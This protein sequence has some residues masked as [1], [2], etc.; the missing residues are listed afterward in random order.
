METSM[1]YYILLFAIFLFLKNYL[2]KTNRQLPPSPGLSLPI[3]GHLY[4]FKKPIHK[5][6]AKLSDKYGPIVYIKFGSRPVILVS[7]PSAVEECFTKHDVAFA[8]RPKLLAG[9]Y[10]GY[11]YT[12]VTWA[13]YG[14]HWRNLRR[15]SSI[16]LLSSNRLQILQGIRA[17]EVSSLI[18]RLFRGSNGGEFQIL[19]MKSTFFQLTLNVM[20]RIVAGKRY[21][22]ED[23]ADLEEAKRFQQIVAETFQLT[24]VTN[25]G[26]FVPV[27][28]YVGVSKLEKK[29][30]ILQKKRDKFLQDL[31]VQHRQMQ[32]DSASEQRSKTMVDV[33]LS[34]QG[35]EPEYYTDE[36]IRGMMHVML[37]AGTDTTSGTMEWAL[38]LLLNNPEA[39]AKA[40]SEIDE[41]IGQSRLVEESDLAKLPYLSCIINET[42]RMYPAAPLLPPHEASE[43][44]TVGGFHVPRGT[45]LLV[46]AWAIQ[47]DPELWAKPELFKPER[48]Q[49]LQGERDGFKWLPFGTG[50]RGCPGEGLA[51]RIVGLA[52]GS[53]IQCFEWERS[54]EEMVDMT[55]RAGLAMPKAH[56]LLAKCRPRPTMLAFLSQLQVSKNIF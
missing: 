36:I 46:N 39:L 51:T 12:T 17:D 11:N 2:Q 38:S 18:F 28:N 26:D 49:N 5:T 4:L 48:F 54:G 44:C 30:L 23:I 42:L 8:N 35:T 41:Q 3:I 24:G 32:S 6:L 9:K 21:Y 50:R 43:D 14:S 10:L 16:E 20:M 53:L 25:I 13:S 7:S 31:I 15:I 22:G 40:Q 45:M 27:L 52:L 55:E 1:Y 47:N 37:T 34:L 19:E 56:P 33:M 29:L